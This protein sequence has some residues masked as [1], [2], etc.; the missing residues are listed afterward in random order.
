MNFLKKLGFLFLKIGKVVIADPSITGLSGTSNTLSLITQA[1]SIAE[2]SGS[3]NG[4]TGQQKLDG[5]VPF[6]AQA[7]IQ[8]SILS[9]KKI[10]D[11]AK[12]QSACKAIT[13]GFA[14]LLSS[15]DGGSVKE[16]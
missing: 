2:I 5:A 1:V 3:A 4:L 16:G 10:A 8:S 7:I 11:E 9:G 14:D 12:F 15:L 6:V 13:G